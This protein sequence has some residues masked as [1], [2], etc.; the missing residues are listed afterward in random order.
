MN[1]PPQA[2]LLNS[3]TWIHVLPAAECLCHMEAEKLEW[4]MSVKMAIACQK[5]HAAAL[6]LNLPLFS[7]TEHHI[8]LRMTDSFTSSSV[9]SPLPIIFMCVLKWTPLPSIFSS[10]QMPKVRHLLSLFLQPQFHYLFLQ[11][12]F[13]ISHSSFNLP[14]DICPLHLHR[15]ELP[16]LSFPPPNLNCSLQ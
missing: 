9:C 15:T 8:H 11:S 4:G 16:F 7:S 6:C 13:S 12:P 2:L 3:V 10:P 1:V 5:L 14:L